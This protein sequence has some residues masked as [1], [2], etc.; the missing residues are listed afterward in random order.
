[1]LADQQKVTASATTEG[2]EV[3]VL[4]RPRDP[5]ISVAVLTFDKPLTITQQAYV[6]P[7]PDGKL[8]FTPFD[9]DAHGGYTGTVKVIGAGKKAYLGNWMNPEWAVEY[10]VNYPEGKKWS[11]T[12]E[13]AAEKAVTLVVGPKGKTTKV[14]ISATG[15]ANLW[16]TVELG[17]VDLPKGAT[18][19]NFVGAKTDWSPIQ[20]RNVTFTP[21]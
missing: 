11:L 20:I 4:G 3:S 19:V 14:R 5:N 1:M 15:G 8:T 16:Q 13:V 18:G 17:T 10:V 6:I 9:A 12:A 7:D 21:R 2:I